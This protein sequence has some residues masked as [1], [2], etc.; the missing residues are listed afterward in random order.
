MRFAHFAQLYLLIVI[1]VLAG[2]RSDDTSATETPPAPPVAVTIALETDSVVTPD[3]LP[4]P[5]V[6]VATSVSGDVP[7]PAQTVAVDEAVALAILEPGEGA[8]LQAGGAFTVRGTASGGSQVRIALLQIGVGVLVE[9]TAT[10]ENDAWSAT[11]TTPA[12]LVG[13]LRLQA[14]LMDGSGSVLE[15][16]VISLSSV[17]NLAAAAY[18]EMQT[19]TM[20]DSAMAGKPVRFSGEA[21][22]SGETAPIT[23]VI[24]AED[25]VTVLATIGFNMVGSGVWEGFVNVPPMVVGPICATATLGNPDSADAFTA[26]TPLIAIDPAE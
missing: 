12:Q 23:L 4:L 9:T 11:L 26:Y 5:T 3:S 25:C 10:L 17:P 18:I 13:P 15:N 19:P 2:C 7:T 24:A 20:A 14:E 8:E 1:L 6:V 16:A 21:K 22:F